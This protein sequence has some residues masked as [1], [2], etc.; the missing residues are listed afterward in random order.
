MCGCPRSLRQTTPE[1]EAILSKFRTPGAA[2]VSV[3]DVQ[4]RMVGRFVNEAIMCLQVLQDSAAKPCHHLCLVSAPTLKL[5]LC[6]C[7]SACG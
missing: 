4:M 3:E 1:A 6:G 5:T 7:L 2:P